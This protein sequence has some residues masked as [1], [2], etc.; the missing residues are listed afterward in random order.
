MT[1]VILSLNSK[2]VTFTCQNKTVR[3]WDLLTEVVLYRC[4]AT[5]FVKRL[6]F[7]KDELYLELGTG[8]LNFLL[9]FF[10]IYF[11]H[12]LYIIHLTKACFNL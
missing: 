6:S 2:L 4:I 11:S 12:Q 9:P 10:N 8:F 7:S 1:T 5:L 3:L